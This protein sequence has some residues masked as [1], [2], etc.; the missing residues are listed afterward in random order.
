MKGEPAGLEML[1]GMTAL[2]EMTV[3]DGQSQSRP[4]QPSCVRKYEYG[5]EGRTTGEAGGGD[6]GCGSLVVCDPIGSWRFYYG[7]SLDGRD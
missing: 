6:G 2:E 1:A 5:G 3:C 4:D 7:G